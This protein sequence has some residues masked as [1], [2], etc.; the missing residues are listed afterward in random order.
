MTEPDQTHDVAVDDRHDANQDRSRLAAWKGRG[1]SHGHA[2]DHGRYRDALRHRDLRVLTAALLIDQIGSWSYGVVISVYLFD[3][4]HST[5]WLAALGRCRW[6]PGLLLSSYGGV[7]ADRYERV[8][9][10]FTSAM[11]SAALM[12]GM[13]VVVASDAPVGLVL[14]ISTM[15]SAAL[16]PTS[17][18][19]A[20]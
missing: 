20:R 1:R 2:E 3:R 10:L 4:T 19:P 16:C 7:I 9:V 15:S 13:A 18:P 5:Q 11:A 6:G 14:A 8:T 12:A 17:L